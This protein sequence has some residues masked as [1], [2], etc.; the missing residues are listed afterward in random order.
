M[1]TT[2]FQLRSFV[3]Q[4]LYAAAEEILGEVEKTITL[5]LYEAEVSRSKEEVESLRHQLDLLRK[6]P[7]GETPRTSSTVEVRDNCDTPP[8]EEHAGCSV[9]DD[10]KLSLRSE[11]PGHCQTSDRLDNKNWNYCQAETD[12]KIPEIKEERE[13]LVAEGQT[14]G[15]VFPSSEIV[16]NEQKQPETEVSYEMQPVSS[17]CSSA[18]SENNDSDEELVKSK[19]NQIDTIQFKE[20]ILPGQIGNGDKK[21]QKPLPFESRSA[22]CQ[23]DRSFCHLCGKAFQYIGSL[24]KH[25]KAHESQTDCTVCGMTY[26]S[27]R[28]LITHLQGCHN[29]TY[30]CDVCGKTFASN[31]CLLV[32][33]KIHTGVKDFVCQEC[34]KTFYRREHLVVHVRTHS[35]EKPYPCDICGKAF[36]QSQNLT[37]HKRSHSGE[38]P[39]HCGLCGKLFNTSS[40]LKTHMR[41]H[42]GEKPYPC[43]ICGKRFRQ[44][45][46]MTRHR[47]THTGERPYACHICGMRYRFAPNLKVHQQT[48]EKLAGE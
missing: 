20:K 29:I 25:I 2:M 3:H 32:H 41:Y 37:I 5:A 7:A 13:E 24:M 43:D 26:Q 21:G 27:T 11:A 9:P 40:H 46:Q 31:R 30:F 28:E 33:K 47:T 8:L 48:H 6:K 38:R 42:S 16:K 45:G 19:G 22:R 1:E 18:Q 10:S 12:F 39:Y 44:S 23:K 17:E 4:R 14:P 35:G 36:S 34:G 15:I